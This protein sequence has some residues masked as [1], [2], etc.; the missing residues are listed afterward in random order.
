MCMIMFIGLSPISKSF[1]HDMRA[2]A[3]ARYIANQG[4]MISDGT[5]KVLFDP[6]PL[7]GFGIYMDVPAEDE[8]AMMAGSPPY[9]LIDAVFISHAHRDHFSASRMVE[10]MNAQTQARLVAPQQALD[11]MLRDESWDPNLMARITAFDMEYG[12]VPEMITIGDITASAVRIPHAGWPAP[13]RAM[14]QNMVYRVTLGGGAVVMHMGDADVRREHYAPFAAH[15]QAKRTDTAF[16]P[17]WFLV[18]TVGTDILYND[19]NIDTAIGTHVPLDVPDDLKDSGV[20]YLH[21]SGEHRTI[22]QS[23]AHD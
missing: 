11:M 16:P 14:V 23:H 2:S 8:A 19:M 10:F 12:D 7:S 21:I 1:A 13:R 6:L 5:V 20:D 22:R 4:V 17:Y 3:D 18:S 9:D 15:W